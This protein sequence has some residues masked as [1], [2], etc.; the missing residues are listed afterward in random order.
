VDIMLFGRG[1]AADR[2]R[3]RHEMGLDKPITT[4]YWNFMQGAIHFDFGRSIVSRD[5]VWH[6]ILVR[7]PN[8]LQLII[9]A[10]VLST[11]IGLVAGS[12]SAIYSRRSLGLSIT[13]LSVL[14]IS[15]PA[16]WV[17]TMLALIFGVELKILP[18]AGMG[19]F[20][21]LILPAITLA[22][23]L[24]ASLTRIVRSTM[25]QVLGM[26]Y[27]RTAKAKGVRKSVITFKHVLRNAMIPVVTVLGLT[28]ANLFGGAV[29]IENVFAWPGLGTLAVQAAGA[30]DFP[31]IQ[32]TVF[33]FAVVLI[34]A[35]LLVDILYAVVDPRIHYS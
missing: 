24:S 27:V 34:G 19:G 3:L 21:N 29:I 6:E 20:K 7:L 9:A 33:F 12:V 23:P 8:S 31:V 1:T 15:M 11:V 16:Y 18:V 35:N 2:I 30:R 26:D 28:L 25:L 17:G 5:T 4:Q 14:G 10:F 13:G 22:I 32:G